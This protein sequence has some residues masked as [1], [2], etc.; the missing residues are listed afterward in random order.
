MVKEDRNSEGMREGRWGEEADDTKKNKKKNKV[1]KQK[2]VEN[3][4]FGKYR[5][6]TA[7]QFWPFRSSD[8]SRN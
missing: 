5:L 4:Q 3:K 2:D 8:D 6:R 7:W 1:K